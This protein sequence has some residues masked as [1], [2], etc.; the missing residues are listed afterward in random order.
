M[1]KKKDAPAS[2]HPVSDDEKRKLPA[3]LPSVDTV[4]PAEKAKLAASLRAKRTEI[5]FISSARSNPR[6]SKAP[7]P[8]KPVSGISRHYS[9]KRPQAAVV[10]IDWVFW[11]L[12]RFVEDWQAAALSLD[13]NPDSLLHHPQAWMAGSRK[14]LF[15]SSSFLNDAQEREFDKR[16]RLV[17]AWAREHGDKVRYFNT[18]EVEL[19]SLATWFAEN[20]IDI[21]A[22]IRSLGEAA[23][24]RR[25][26]RG[27]GAVEMDAKPS[28]GEIVW[29][30]ERRK[31]LR[32][33][34]AKL[35]AKG[36]HAPT[37]ELA[38]RYK[39]S[40]ARIRE[41]KAKPNGETF[42]GK[43]DQLIKKK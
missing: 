38:K 14:A 40:E 4:T 39:V 3:R 13:I 34:H 23:A 6:V 21:S 20:D 29:T 43:W 42:G 11:R 35:M 32:Q 25:A 8:G 9:S 22:E 10:P 30:P 2:P 36:A 26:S 19:A 28:T 33:E 15:S 37:K 24:S 41:L 18:G 16:Y 5:K 17:A 1:T 27:E 7:P 31:E 12:H